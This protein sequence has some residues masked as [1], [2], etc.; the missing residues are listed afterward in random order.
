MLNLCY[1][2]IIDMTIEVEFINYIDNMV[3]TL[4][5]VRT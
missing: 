2:S 5:F 1:L 4:F 3:S